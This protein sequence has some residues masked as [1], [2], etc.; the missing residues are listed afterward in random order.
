M[1]TRK[2][3][4]AAMPFEGH[5]NPLTGIARYLQSQGHDVRWYAG[6]SYARKLAKLEIP[7]YPFQKAPEI[8]QENMDAVLPDRANH[9]GAIAKLKFDIK[10]VFVLPIPDMMTDIEQIHKEFKFDVIVC[11]NAFAAGYIVREKFKVPLVSI[12][13]LPLSETSKDLAPMGLGLTPPNNFFQ[14]QWYGVLRYLIVKMVLKESSLLFN[15]ILRQFG[16][17]PVAKANSIFDLAPRESDV[18]LQS[19]VPGFE[20]PRQDLSPMVR[21]VGPLLPCKSST[22]AGFK[23]L[24]KLSNYKKVILVT[25]GTVERDAEKLLVPTLEAF[26]DTHYLVVVTTGGSQTQQLRERYPHDNIVIEDFIDFRAIMPL[27]DVYVTN[28]GYGGVMLSLENKLPLVVAGVHEGKNEINARVGYFKLGINLKTE[29]PTPG[30]VRQAVERVLTDDTYKR[31]V[32]RL[33]QE[34]ERF[35]PNQLC[36]QYIMEVLEGEERELFKA[37]PLNSF[38]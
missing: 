22:M 10:H 7:H 31:N 8:N 19:G 17:P 6:G 25:Q 15:T 16:V 23:H 2:I 34:F 13:V 30:Q 4:F 5:F 36:E 1:K 37:R 3:L 20:Y 21:F 24:N 18:Y 33:S 26:K 28:G 12:G 32:H 27:A 38:A 11:D 35:N 29:T 14:R 9:K